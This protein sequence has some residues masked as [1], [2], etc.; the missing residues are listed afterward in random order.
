MLKQRMMLQKTKM[1]KNKV[2]DLA[3]IKEESK[4]KEK[5]NN[6]S[7]GDRTVFDQSYI[8]QMEAGMSDE[9]KGNFKNIGEDYYKNL[10]INENG[11]LENLIVLAVFEITEALKSGLHPNELSKEDIDILV[12]NL[13]EDWYLQFHFE[14][15]DFENKK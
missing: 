7:L 5:E 8:K 2:Y 6:I 3:M 14:K 13:G 15:K 11:D 1:F 12:N 4:E 9:Q 10:S